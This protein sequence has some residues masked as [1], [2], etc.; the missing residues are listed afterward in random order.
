MAD[1]DD[2]RTLAKTL[3]SHMERRLILNLHLSRKSTQWKNMWKTVWGSLLFLLTFGVL[4]VLVSPLCQ[5]TA[6]NTLV[7]CLFMECITTTAHAHI[8]SIMFVDPSA[9]GSNTSPLVFPKVHQTVAV[10]ATA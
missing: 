4:W 5:M 8:S 1:T 9:V 2:K 10:A 3:P 6:F 7:Y